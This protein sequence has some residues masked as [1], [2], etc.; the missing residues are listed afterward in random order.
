MSKTTKQDEKR[1]FGALD[2]FGY[3][4]GDVGNGLTFGFASSFLMVF[5]TNIL[6]ISPAIVGVLFLVARFVDAVT[7]VGMGI[8]VDRAAPAKD[9]KFKCWIRRMCIPVALASF[10]MYQSGLAGASMTVKIIYMFVT[11]FLWGS[12]TYTAINIPYGSMPAVIT[13]DPNERAALST[14]RS[15]G[16]LGAII[17]VSVVAPQ[18]IYHEIDGQQV[19]SGSSFMLLAGILSVVALVCYFLCHR[20]TTERISA[21]KASD[22]NKPSLKESFRALATNRALISLL[23]ITILFV[24]A[25]F[26]TQTMNSYLF[27]NWFNNKNAASIASIS[28]LPFILVLTVL[29]GK[30]TARFGKKISLVGSLVYGI[31]L[32]VVG[33]LKLESPWVYILVLFLFMFGLAYF[34][35]VIWAFATD[36]IDDIEVKSGR[37]ESGTVYG[38][39]SFSRKMG[40]ALAGGLC[41]FALSA[42]NYVEGAAVQTAAVN[43][44]IYNISTFIPGITYV[45]IAVFLLL[46]YPLS[47]DKVR[48]NSLALG[49]GSEK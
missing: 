49:K 32:I 39:F 34:N 33:F 11:Y 47:R 48:E 25:T 35:V 22:E 3:L 12:I 18:V 45:V 4:F 44:G 8:I 28:Q 17:I 2:K 42:V 15:T 26:V 24:M 20:M 10:L 23:V 37:S 14:F 29:V 19:A 5:Y 31:A 36:V 46:T 7:D 21:L 9:G 30:L 43:T 41:G 38:V 40:Q 6:E 27:I 16:S 1:P 13:E